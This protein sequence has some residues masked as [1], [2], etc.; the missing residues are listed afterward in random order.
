[1]ALSS[2]EA[3]YMAATHG[4]KEALS[5]MRFLK[6]LGME[7]VDLEIFSDNQSSLKLMKNDSCHGRTKHIDVKYHYIRDLVKEGTINFQYLP[8]GELLADSLTKPVTWEKTRFCA[9]GMGLHESADSI[10]N[11]E[12]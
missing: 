1:V 5:L 10:E 4:A 2:T 12:N 6:E 8:S 11:Q 7:Q 9:R 3:E